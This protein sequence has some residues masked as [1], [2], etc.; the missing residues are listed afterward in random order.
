MSRTSIRTIAAVAALCL[1]L[2]ACS[3][4]ESDGTSSPG[5][6]AGQAPEPGVGGEKNR[7]VKKDISGVPGVTDSEIAYTAVGTKAGN[8][9]G[10]CILDCYVDGIRAYFAYRNSEGGIY[11]RKLVLNDPVDDEL[12]NN[13]ARALDLTTGNDAFGNFQATLVASGWGDLDSAAI[14]TYVW[15]IHATEAANRPHI[16]AS[17]PVQCTDCTAQSYPYLAEQAGATKGATVGYGISEASKNC[18]GAITASYELFAEDSGV[19]GVYSNDGLA[20]G[21]PNGI[22]PEVTAMKKAGVDFIATCIDLNGMKTLA[23]ELDRQ[24]MS[25][26]VLMHPNTYNQDFVA[27]NKDLFEGDYVV[28]QFLPFEASG[29]GTA[30]PEFKKWMAEQGSQETELA[31]T[32]WINATTAYDGLLAAGPDFDR[33]KVTAATNAMTGYTADGLVEPID[34]TQAH[35]PYTSESRDGRP[36]SCNAAVIVKAGKFRTVASPDEPWLC[37]NGDPA[38]WSE[39]TETSFE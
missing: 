38:K 16:F 36:D 25:D 14:P 5:T 27:Q 31:M 15:G 9:L 33:D 19:E 30:L 18:V 21:L 4:S 26:V 34:W 37:W 20:F 39:P 1:V 17:L 11:G 22:G 12:G 28:P 3:N 35:V 6:A 24:G 7:D 10:N 32:G 2:G 8:P 23:Q 13:Q 29:E